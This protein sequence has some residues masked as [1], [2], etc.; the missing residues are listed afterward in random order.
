LQEQQVEL[1]LHEHADGE[2]AVDDLAARQQQQHDGGEPVQ[3]HHERP[4]RFLDAGQ[5][6]VAADVLVVQLLELGALAVLDGEA[7]EGADARERFLREVG[8][9]GELVLAQVVVAADQA[10]QEEEDEA[11]HRQQG[12]HGEGELQVGGVHE[13]EGP[14]E[15]DQHAGALQQAL[16][17]HFAHGAEV[18]RHLGHQVAGALALEERVVELRQV[19]EHV[20]L[21]VVLH[22]VGQAQ[23][24]AAHADGDEEREG[25]DA[26]VQEHQARE[27]AAAQAVVAQRI[28]GPL[29]QAGRPQA[30]PDVA[31][32]AYKAQGG[33]DAVGAQVAQQVGCRHGHG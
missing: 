15:T 9:G 8:D 31:G 13:A 20:A 23:H 18:G 3:Q 2:G 10:D 30:G 17:D 14:R 29:H 19:R 32:H 22:V 24:Q 27:L 11:D 12:R 28:D 1:E 16:P 26:Q 4:H 25:R 21:D 5:R 7:L 33:L 6:H